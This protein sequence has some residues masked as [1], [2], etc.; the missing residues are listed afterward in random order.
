MKNVFDILENYIKKI[1]FNGNIMIADR[2][3]SIVYRIFRQYL[4]SGRKKR[5]EQSLGFELASVSKPFTAFAILKVLDIYNLSLHTDVK[6]FLPDFPIMTL[7]FISCSTIHPD[8]RTI[9]N[10]LKHFGIKQL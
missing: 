3:K 7:L 8:C 4:S 6:Y 1:K 2:R 9:W 10:Y 5:T